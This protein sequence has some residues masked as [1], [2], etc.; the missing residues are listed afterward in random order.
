[1]GGVIAVT[2]I[3]PRYAFLTKAKYTI[4]FGYQARATAVSSRDEATARC[5]IV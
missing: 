2:I 4:M 1:M 3:S 5:I